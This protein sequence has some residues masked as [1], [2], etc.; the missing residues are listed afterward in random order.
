[1]VEATTFFVPAATTDNQ[2]SIY[3]DFAK[4]CGR[5]VPRPE[6]RIYSI[7]F[8]HGGEEWTATVGET[9]KCKRFFT[10][11]SR[12][13]KIEREQPVSDPA[14]VLA[15]FPGILYMVVTNHRLGG[16]NVVSRWENPFFVGGPDSVTVS[17]VAQ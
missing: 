9:L 15:T 8:S 13:M 5:A 7:T 10:M 14:I 4:L 17:S 1:M 12:G 3:A 16:R 11:R 6:R 2:E